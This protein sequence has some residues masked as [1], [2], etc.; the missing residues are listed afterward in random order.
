MSAKR[1]F[2]DKA[3]NASD[4][5][6]KQKKK[7]TVSKVVSINH[8]AKE[9]SLIQELQSIL[10]ESSGSAQKRLDDFF[11]TLF[12]NRQFIEV[13]TDRFKQWQVKLSNLILEGQQSF[14]FINT[15]SPME[16]SESL[17][18]SYYG[19]YK[20]CEFT[21]REQSFDIWKKTSH[22]VLLS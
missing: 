8:T 4:E 19:M 21:N 16:L 11:T 7:N 2:P 1:T 13:G 14:E 17:L 20:R 5:T 18:V 15:I 6:P 9:K 10:S 3:S 22:R 12:E